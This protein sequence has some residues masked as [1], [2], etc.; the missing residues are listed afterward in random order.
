MQILRDSRS[1]EN[2]ARSCP[3][4]ELR[5]LLAAHIENL[6]GYE[7]YELGELVNFIVFEGGDTVADLDVI[8]GFPIMAN[9]LDGVRFGETDFLPSWEVIEEHINWFEVVYVLSDDGFGV[10]VF[11]SKNAD[12]ELQQMLSQ[13]ASQ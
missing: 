3:D 10:V 6:S 5:Q 13:F 7:G 1:I 11:I 8:L 9:R 12:P 4:P 2:G